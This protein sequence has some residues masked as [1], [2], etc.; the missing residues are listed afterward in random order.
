MD[1]TRI[2]EL[3]QKRDEIDQAIR[4]EVGA[5]E[6]RKSRCSRCGSEDHT[7]RNCPQK[8]VDN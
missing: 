1:T 7:A 8:T 3:L 5:E 4:D 2:R 6:R